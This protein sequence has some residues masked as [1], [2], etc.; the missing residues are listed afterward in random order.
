MTKEDKLKIANNKITYWSRMII[1]YNNI[2]LNAKNL[3]IGNCIQAFGWVFLILILKLYM[4]WGASII[5]G[6]CGYIL[7]SRL[8]YTVFKVARGGI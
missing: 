6:I 2:K 1:L 4:P 7:F 3:D 5:W 8:E